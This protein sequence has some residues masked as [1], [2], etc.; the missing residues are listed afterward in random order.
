MPRPTI[1]AR[2]VELWDLPNNLLP[3][4]PYVWQ[5]WPTVGHIK[6]TLMTGRQGKKVKDGRLY[7]DPDH[8]CK[9]IREWED[10][11]DSRQLIFLKKMWA[12]QKIMWVDHKRRKARFFATLYRH[13]LRPADCRI[14]QRG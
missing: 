13:G 4:A 9:L 7:V 3:K 12:S 1:T 10:R 2:G 14:F 5:K 8:A 11:Q 6:F